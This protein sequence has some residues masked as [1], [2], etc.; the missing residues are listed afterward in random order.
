MRARSSKEQTCITLLICPNVPFVEAN[1]K[2]TGASARVTRNDGRIAM[3]DVACGK[4]G[5]VIMSNFGTT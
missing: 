3:T 4:D 5:P 2:S 1:G